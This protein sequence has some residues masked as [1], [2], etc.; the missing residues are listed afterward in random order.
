MTMLSKSFLESTVNPFKSFLVCFL[1]D[2]LPDMVV[3]QV[4]RFGNNEPNTEKQQ[5]DNCFIC[6]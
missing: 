3:Y 2:N 5:A 6:E 4:V 1:T